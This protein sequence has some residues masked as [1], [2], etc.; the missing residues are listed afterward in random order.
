MMNSGIFANTDYQPVVYD[1][2]IDD[3]ENIVIILAISRN[4]IS[5]ATTTT[6]LSVLGDVVSGSRHLLDLFEEEFVREKIEHEI[7][8][9]CRQEF[10]TVYQ[11]ELS[12][13]IHDAVSEYGLRE[14]GQQRSVL[15]EADSNSFWLVLLHRAHVSLD[16]M[17]IAMKAED[18]IEELSKRA[19]WAK[20]MASES[21]PDWWEV[22]DL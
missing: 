6:C 21:E 17:L 8:S 22:L 20:L 1:V 4:I 19:M 12:S 7:V 10:D 11:R 18:A 5:N 2:E 13:A 15:V 16:D 3:Q 9:R 14:N